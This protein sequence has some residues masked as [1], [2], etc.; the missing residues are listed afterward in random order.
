MFKVLVVDDE[1]N[2]RNLMKTVLGREGFEVFLAQNGKIGL[3]IMHQEKIDLLIVDIMMPVMNGFDFTKEVRKMNDSIP[4]LM[5][6]AKQTIA[7]KKHGF[8]LG[9]DDYMVKPVDLEEMV[10]R[11][12]ALLRRAK[13]STEKRLVIKNTV[14]DYETFTVT[15]KDETIELPKHEFLLIFYLLSYKGKIFTRRKLLENVWNLS[16]SDEHTIDVHI[17]RLR[18]RFKDN[19]DF[20]IVTVRGLGYKVVEK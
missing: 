18:N 3:D 14:L 12:H 2:A 16:D 10:L 13:I 11:I 17:N 19:E 5:I 15:T 9:I 20:E 8:L 6:T 7:D 4:I 1:Q